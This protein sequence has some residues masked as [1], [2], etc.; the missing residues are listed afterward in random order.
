MG[1]REKREDNT[2]RENSS[3]QASNQAKQAIKPSTQSIQAHY[4]SR[5]R[6]GDVVHPPPSSLSHLC[7]SLT[8]QDGLQGYLGEK[9]PH[10]GGTKPKHIP[11]HIEIDIP[12]Q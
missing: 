11:W 10:V 9:K 4:R 3:K 2:K 12:M 5:E 8:R 6:R 7:L 1:V